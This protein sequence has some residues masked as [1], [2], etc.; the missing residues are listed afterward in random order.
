MNAIVNTGELL[1]TAVKVNE[2]YRDGKNSSIYFNEYIQDGNRYVI[3]FV[4]LD[5]VLSNTSLSQLYSLSNKKVARLQGQSPLRTT[6]I[7]VD[8]LLK[9][10]IV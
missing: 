4:V 7:S 5:G 9:M 1:K 10:S 3:R 6:T 2:A 8:N